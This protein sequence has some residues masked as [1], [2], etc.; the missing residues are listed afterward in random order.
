[1]FGELGKGFQR[2]NIALPQE[3]LKFALNQLKDTFN[4]QKIKTRI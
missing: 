3:D 1:M 4:K 2:I